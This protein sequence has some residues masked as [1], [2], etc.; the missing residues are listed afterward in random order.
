MHLFLL[1]GTALLAASFGG[2]GAHAQE[3]LPLPGANP[4]R[5]AKQANEKIVPDVWSAQEIAA[6]KSRC[7]NLL[8]KIDVQFDV[9]APITTGRCGDAAPV[10]LKA[11]GNDPEV[12]ISPPAKLSCPMVVALYK[13]ATGP[14]QATS[15]DLLGARITRIR[16]V[17]SYACRNR[18]NAAN[19][20]LSEHAFANAL[21]I[22]TLI[23]DKGDGVD[24]LKHWGPARRDLVAAAKHSSKRS[25]KSAGAL[26]GPANR[27]IAKRN[28]IEPRQALELAKLKVRAS[29]LELRAAELAVEAG[30]N[31]TRADQAQAVLATAENAP[32]DVPDASAS[33][34]AA[35]R[36]VTVVGA[37]TEVPLPTQNLGRTALD[38]AR[39]RAQRNL[40]RAENAQREFEVAERR[41]Q[42]AQQRK[43]RVVKRAR[44]D[45]ERRNRFATRAQA[46]AKRAR[47]AALEAAQAVTQ[48]EREFG[49]EGHGWLEADNA[50]SQATP[51]GEN[52]AAGNDMT[53]LPGGKPPVPRVTAKGRFLRAVHKSACG[54][55][56]TVLGPEANE[57]H[58]NHFHFDL[59]TRRRRAYCE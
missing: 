11:V 18:N 23:T 54:I 2:G 53:L 20:K 52:S 42:V 46:Q 38:R 50:S 9:L 16:N 1:I 27:T 3:P 55:F 40:A 45:V 29:K 21:D 19:G 35:A 25:A 33:P 17:S 22:A 39:R 7:L 8:S 49:I 58:R 28:K 37:T 41:R 32:L 36:R 15:R 26:G 47:K 34:Q 57:A 12:R 6:A 5:K 30:K 51:P 56:G 13:W 44:R 31:R 4:A 48:R 43:E 14:L 24:I 10:L 59:A